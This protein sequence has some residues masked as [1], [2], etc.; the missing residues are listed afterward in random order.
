MILRSVG[1]TGILQPSKVSTF[2]LQSTVAQEPGSILDRSVRLQV[3]LWASNL[4]IFG[5]ELSNFSVVHVNL[6]GLSSTPSQH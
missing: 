1:L 2:F 4:H 5:L 6:A 3:L